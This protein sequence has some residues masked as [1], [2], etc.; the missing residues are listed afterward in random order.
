[1]LRRH[2]SYSD[3]PQTLP[4]ASYFWR[5]R[6]E[7]AAGHA[8]NWAGTAEGN[9]ASTWQFTKNDPYLTG[10]SVANAGSHRPDVV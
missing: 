3:L 9:L 2:H 7:D 5:V 10:F 1:M 4:H 6:G 8:T